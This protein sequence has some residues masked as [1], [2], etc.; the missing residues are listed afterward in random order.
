M[1]TT[2][3]PTLV[4]WRN[5][6]ILIT[7]EPEPTPPVTLSNVPTATP[8]E[9]PAATPS[10]EIAPSAVTVPTPITVVKNQPRQR[11]FL[12]AF[13]ISFFFGVF[14]VDRMY[15]G[16]WGLGILKLITVGGAGIW[17]IVDL[18]LIMAGYMRD[19]QGREMLQIAEYKKFAKNTILYISL[20][21][22]VLIIVSGVGIALALPQILQLTGGG[23]LPGL[24]SLTSGGAYPQDLQ[25]EL[26][27]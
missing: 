13:F 23:G 4:L 3:T 9:M 1:K 5:K 26:S 12:A 16:F 11:H 8:L 22:G 7:M 14:G 25:Q 27:R 20:S 15:M 6:R 2:T 24:D 21:F 10:A 17:V 18:Y 19:K